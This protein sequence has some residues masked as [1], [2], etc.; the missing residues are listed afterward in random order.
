MQ[1]VQRAMLPDTGPM[2]LAEVLLG[3]LLRQLPGPGSRPCYVYADGVQE[4]LLNSLGQD[5]AALVLKHC[6]SYVERNFG[7]GARNFPALA[8]ARLSE[9][10]GRTGPRPPAGPE[11]G[12]GGRDDEVDDAAGA[13][14]ELFARVPARVLRFYQPDLVT[15]V[16]LDEAERLLDQWHTQADPS[17]LRAPASGSAALRG[18]GAHGGGRAPARRPVTRPGERGR[19]SC[20]GGCCSRK[21]G[22]RPC[23]AP[24]G[25]ANSSCARSTLAEARDRA[26]EGSR[27]R[28]DARLELAAVHH[29][30]W[31][32]THDAPH[33]DAAL[34]ALAGDTSDW[35]AGSRR[36]LHLRRGRL[37][38]V[39]LGQR[40]RY[41]NSAPDVRRWT[42]RAPPTASAAPPSSTSPR[43]CAPRTPR[44]RR[45]PGSWPAPDRPPARTRHCA[46]AA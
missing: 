41:A 46:C 37:L 35:P 18:N 42:P 38:L 26:P 17:L 19:E 11:P 8:A 22:L 15:P 4:L 12:R 2:E 33:L 14:P 45:P 39:L 3:G 10:R 24:T 23:A 27:D 6:S 44:T 31:R 34:D 16:P 25:R 20:W 21:P 30:L 29:A 5:A 32:L 43:P 7:K 36:A 1:L 28:A 9:L 13:V 40:K